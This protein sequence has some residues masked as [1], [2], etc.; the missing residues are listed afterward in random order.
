MKVKM[1]IK[2][3]KQGVGSYTLDESDS[4]GACRDRNFRRPGAS[5]EV[6]AF[7]RR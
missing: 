2:S 1:K 6:E 7:F 3:E 5:G 4:G